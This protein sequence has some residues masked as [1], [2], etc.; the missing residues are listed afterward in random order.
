MQG[1][2]NL[3]TWKKPSLSCSKVVKIYGTCSIIS[4]DKRSV[5]SHQY[6]PQYE[7]FCEWF[8]MASVVPIVIGTA[9]VFKFH[10]RNISI[11]RS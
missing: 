9:F 6:F 3:H 1:I 10:M 11:A 2:Y 7:Y 4:D 5:L 8:Y